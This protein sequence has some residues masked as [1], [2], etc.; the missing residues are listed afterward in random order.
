MV[1]NYIQNLLLIY[2]YMNYKNNIIPIIKW[3]SVD[4]F[5]VII[6]IKL[7]NNLSFDTIEWDKEEDKVYLHKIVE[8]IDYQFDYDDF[9]ESTK[10]EIYY[11][12]ALIFLN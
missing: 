3:L 1:L 6:E 10:K 11:H 4:L 12:I 2:K 5:E 8:D 7:S 9:D